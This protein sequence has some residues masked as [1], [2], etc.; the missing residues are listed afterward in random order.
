MY[1]KDISP[2]V[3][4]AL[5]GSVGIEYNRSDVFR[6]LRTADCR[7]FYILGGSGQ[8]KFRDAAYPLQPEVAILF[9]SGT[10]YM[11]DTQHVDVILINFDFTTNH[12]SVTK[13]FHPVHSGS[14]KEEDILEN[15]VF[16]DAAI[17]NQPLYVPKARHIEPLLR[18]LSSAYHIGGAYSFEMLS[19]YMKAVIT[20]LVYSK[21]STNDETETIDLVQD[22]IRYIQSN[23]QNNLSNEVIAEEFHF[24]SSY[25]G[26]IFK[27]H[28]GSSIHQFLIDYRLNIAK[29]L[30]R[31]QNSSIQSIA[32]SV[33]FH[34]THHFVKYF[35]K[36]VGKTPT[37]YRKSNQ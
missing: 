18:A 27:Q 22:L 19:A 31:S 5:I 2:F 32:L 4:Q 33:G 25:L 24:H 16:E 8:I 37:E 28:T 11:W 21:H 26:R 12:T 29:E 23:Y 9:Q 15:I 1:L 14:F 30:L 3:R 13:S 20:A 36:A 35:K 10:E 34:D 7:L 17:L 6:R